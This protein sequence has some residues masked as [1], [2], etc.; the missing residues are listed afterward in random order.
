[1]VSLHDLSE[2]LWS[3]VSPRKTQQRREKP[4]KIP[5]IPIKAK[6]AKD[7]AVAP[8]DAVVA[9][10]DV[11]VTPKDVAVIQKDVAMTPQTKIGHWQ[12]QTP[13]SIGSVDETLLPTSPPFS[14]Q[15]H[16]EFDGDAVVRES[17]E[18]PL[19]ESSEADW[20]ANDETLVVDDGQYM[21]AQKGIDLE[22]EAQRREV[23][24]RELREAGWTED[25]VFLFQK[26]GMRGFEPLLPGD[27][28][29]DFPTL[30][31]DLFT[32]NENKAFIKAD[33]GSEYRG[34]SSV[35][36]DKKRN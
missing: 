1:M 16:D 14:T 9:S 30:P 24:G 27:W 11:T 34:K 5:A 23:Q 7:C 25:A 20:D 26:L 8:I 10:E 2:R 22:K 36:H 19:Q 17:I 33:S 32:H 13:S 29:N 18:E 3:W 4:F 21:D 12:V 15:S 6:L 35:P 31:V 28:V